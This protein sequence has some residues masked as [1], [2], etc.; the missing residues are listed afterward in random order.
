MVTLH[1]FAFSNYYNIV[2]H[3]LMHKGIPFQ[4]DL[5]YGD[6]PAWPDI[7]PVGK[8]P[9]ITTEEGQHLSESSVC[10]DYLEE[11]YPDQP[12]Y[13]ADCYERNR[14]R[15]IMKV[16]ELYLELPFRRLIPFMFTNS[17][18]PEALANEV[19][20]TAGKGFAAMGR[21]CRFAPYVT[22]PELTM[23]DI[24]LRYVMS[25]VTMAGSSKLDWDTLA[26]VEGLGDWYAMLGDSDIARNIDA[27]QQAN[28][29]QFF[30]HLEQRFGMPMGQG[31]GD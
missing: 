30:A 1:G 7:S 6:D 2:K 15:Q 13:P 28:A 29:P 14:V 17:E 27:D 5:R 18:V 23:A 3:V 12:L 24:Y 25:L 10:C 19:R 11:R 31:I 21:L 8:I 20:E 16:S 4:E 26:E 9:A 22:G